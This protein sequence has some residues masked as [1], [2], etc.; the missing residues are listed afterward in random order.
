MTGELSSQLPD[1]TGLGLNVTLGQVT[2]VAGH[3][4][5]VN[6]SGL[7]SLAFLSD[8]DP[9]F[10]SGDF[11]AVA[12]LDDDEQVLPQDWIAT[13]GS[14]RWRLCTDEASTPERRA[15]EMLIVPAWAVTG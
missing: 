8:V 11:L 10:S 3:C 12:R 1:P 13:R 4:A 2:A 15:S 9:S 5:T 6:V 14:S 7:S